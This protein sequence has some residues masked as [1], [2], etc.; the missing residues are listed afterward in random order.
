LAAFSSS[1]FSTSAFSSSSFDLDSTGT[2]GFVVDDIQNANAT[3]DTVSR[4]NICQR[5]GFKVKPHQLVEEWS[6]AL[7][8]P[9]SFEFRSDQDFIRPLAESLVGPIRPESDDSFIVTSIA[10]EDL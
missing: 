1:S 7:V 2:S 5:T 3:E 4:Y 8:R 9:D 10:P 6:G